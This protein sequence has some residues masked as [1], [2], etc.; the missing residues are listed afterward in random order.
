MKTIW[1]LHFCRLPAAARS[2]FLFLRGKKMGLA[3]RSGLGQLKNKLRMGLDMLGH[4]GLGGSETIGMKKKNWA[5][6]LS[7]E[8]GS[9]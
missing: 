6:K 3:A 1:S 4:N 8:L 9:K 7:Y 5:P 2:G